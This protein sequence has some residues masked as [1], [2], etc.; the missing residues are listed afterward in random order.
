MADGLDGKGRSIAVGE[1]GI[2]GAA[3]I[4]A[5]NIPG[6]CQG[7]HVAVL[8]AALGGKKIVPIPDLINMRTLHEPAAGTL[9]DAAALGQLFAGRDVDLALDDAVFAEIIQSCAGK[10][11]LA[12]LEIEGRIDAV[13]LHI[14]RVRPLPM[15]VIGPHIE[16]LIGGGI[17]GRHVEAAIVVTDGGRKDTAG[18][19]GISQCDLGRPGQYMA[20]L[21]PVH[22]VPALKQR[23]AGKIVEA[24]A[25]HVI[26]PVHETH[27]GVRVKAP[28]YGIFVSH[29]RTSAVSR[30]SRLDAPIWT[31]YTPGITRKAPST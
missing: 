29:R 7:E 8:R 21:C 23:D 20:D 2:V 26:Y 19:A 3:F 27:A 31:S 13:L 18:A 9:P 22:Q 12:V 4:G 16:I 28:E 15:N 1:D 17:G 25:D 14:H 10:E 11:A 6:S 5:P 24:A 30:M